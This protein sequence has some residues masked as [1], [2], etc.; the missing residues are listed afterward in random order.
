MTRE[1]LIRSWEYHMAGF[2]C[3]VYRVAKE[4]L[5]RNGCNDDEFHELINRNNSETDKEIPEKLCWEIINGDIDCSMSVLIDICTRMGYHL[6]L[7]PIEVEGN[8]NEV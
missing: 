1:E 3:E 6:E 2:Q 5:E 7:V 4:F 8:S